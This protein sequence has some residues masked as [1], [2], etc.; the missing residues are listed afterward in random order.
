MKN[1]IMLVRKARKKKNKLSPAQTKK[2][3]S[4]AKKNKDK[5]KAPN[6]F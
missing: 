4:A 1:R 5:S 2:A 6:V 3:Q